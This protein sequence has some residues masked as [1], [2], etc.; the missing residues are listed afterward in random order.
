MIIVATEPH[1]Q[2]LQRTIALPRFARAGAR[3]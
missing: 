3:R 1:N 2:A